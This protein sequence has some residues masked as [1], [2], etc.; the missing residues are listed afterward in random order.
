MNS[1]AKQQQS[2]QTAIPAPLSVLRFSVSALI[3][4]LLVVTN[5][6]ATNTNTNANANPNVNSGHGVALLLIHCPQELSLDQDPDPDSD[7]APKPAI[8]KTCRTNAHAQ[9]RL[10]EAKGLTTHIEFNLTPTNLQYSIQ[11]FSQR[12]PTLGVALIAYSGPIFKAIKQGHEILYLSPGAQKTGASIPPELNILRI[13]NQLKIHSGASHSFLLVDNSGFSSE[14]DIELIHANLMAI[15]TRPNISLFHVNNGFEQALQALSI[16]TLKTAH[17]ATDKVTNGGQA[18]DEWV[19]PLGSVFVWCPPRQ[20]PASNVANE[21]N[22]EV[23][24]GFWLGKYELTKRE[25]DLVT[26]KAPSNALAIE[27]NHP[28]DAIRHDD[29]LQFI[30]ELNRRERFAGRLPEDWEYALPSSAEW[31]YASRAS[32]ANRAEQ[33]GEKKSRYYFGETSEPLPAHANFADKSLLNSPHNRNNE[34]FNYA[35]ASIDDGHAQ[36]ALVGSYQANPWGLHDVYGNLWEWTADSDEAGFPIARGCSWASIADYCD[37]DFVHQ[38]AAQTE[39]NF[40]GFRLAL[41]RKPMI[42]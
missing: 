31:G 23:L 15:K 42:R 32:F 24:P 17:H 21:R 12:T 34:Y 20:A 36:L 5:A 29:I 41:R 35:D 39:R 3:L 2:R 28:R 4:L 30:T 14:D 25:F 18:G 6:T 13:L 16:P 37:S 9:S 7:Q 8:T 1:R 26:Y 19:N 38:F 11:A 33:A 22:R 27:P 40:I 10:L